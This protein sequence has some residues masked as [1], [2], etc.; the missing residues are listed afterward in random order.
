[1]EYIYIG[2]IVNT[3]GIKG[4][5]R[6]LSRFD[7]KEKVF[8]PNTLIY[9]GEEKIEEKIVSYRKH[10]SFDM[11][12]LEGINDIN[13]VLKYKGKN[14]YISSSS[15]KLSDNEILDED[16]IGFTA[17]YEDKE[18][19]IVNDIMDYGNKV[20]KIN[21]SLIPYN[22]NFILKL[23]KENKKIYLK[24]VEGLIK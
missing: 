20:L 4:E 24:N 21:E 8:V 2:K 7:F 19:G 5:V 12:L 10:K 17:L 9:I 13:D 1:M 11:V 23:N 6:I 22:E 18:I 16:L 14:V 15:L 3:H